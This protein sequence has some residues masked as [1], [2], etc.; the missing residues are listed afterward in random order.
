MDANAP[1][2]LFA[3]HSIS[4]ARRF[5]WDTTG[6]LRLSNADAAYTVI[7]N[8]WKLYTGD[9]EIAKFMFDSLD[10]IRR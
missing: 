1:T 8:S 5:S 4:A 6:K 7:H 2:I 10:N 3:S 9:T